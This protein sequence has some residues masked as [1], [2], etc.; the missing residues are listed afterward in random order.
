MTW[1]NLHFR[2]PI[3]TPIDEDRRTKYKVLIRSAGLPHT[4]V[5]GFIVLR[6]HDDSFYHTVANGY[7][8]TLIIDTF[9]EWMEVPE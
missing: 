6:S 7:E 8:E 1:K 2:P 5:L 9:Y 4:E 3:M